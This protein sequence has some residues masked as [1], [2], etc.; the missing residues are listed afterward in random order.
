MIETTFVACTIGTSLD[1][2]SREG[3]GQNSTEKF[4]KV[5][6]NSLDIF[7]PVR[8]GEIPFVLWHSKFTLNLQTFPNSLTVMY[9]LTI[10]SLIL[11]RLQIP[12]NDRRCNKWEQRKQSGLPPFQLWWTPTPQDS[13]GHT[14]RRALLQPP[15]C[16]PDPSTNQRGGGRA[17]SAD[18]HTGLE[19]GQ[20]TLFNQLLYNLECWQTILTM[21]IPFWSWGLQT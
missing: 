21:S 7:S 11:C 5:G 16:L 4:S 17:S 13:P 3:E 2:F 14:W 1:M 8:E 20:F 9:K 19:K 15:V 10:D 12:W 6:R 18:R